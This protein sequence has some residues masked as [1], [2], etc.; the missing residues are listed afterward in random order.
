MEPPS[1]TSQ[2]VYSISMKLVPISSKGTLAHQ[3]QTQ[4]SSTTV[5]PSVIGE[6]LSVEI[7]VFA[8]PTGYMLTSFGFSLLIRGIFHKFLLSDR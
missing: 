1:R 3:V 7:L 4:G 6:I 8:S 2:K 5:L